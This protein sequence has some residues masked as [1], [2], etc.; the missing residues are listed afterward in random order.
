MNEYRFTFNGMEKDDEVKGNGNSYDF[1]AR[2]H[3]SRIGRFLSLDPRKFDFPF[4][5][6]YCFAAN[7]PIA[8]IDEYG[9]GPQKPKRPKT[10]AV[11]TP[12]S[13]SLVAQQATSKLRGQMRYPSSQGIEM[14]I[15]FEDLSLS[16][17]DVDGSRKGNATIGF[18]HKVHDGAI[19][20]GASEKGLKKPITMNDAVELLAADI[21]SINGTLS[22]RVNNRKLSNKMT[23]NEYDLAFDLEFN[24]GN[25][26]RYLDKLGK[27]KDLEANG[28]TTKAD[29]KMSKLT[30]WVS[31]QY[32]GRDKKRGI[33]RAYLNEGTYGTKETTFEEVE[34]IGK[35]SKKK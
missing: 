25:S 1:G 29:K 9:E 6:P 5:S 21:E 35:K 14:T 20:G 11:L 10:R 15:S 32:P 19:N 7:N 34:I 28:K 17:Y 31:R 16:L 12:F 13:A 2:I 24:T 18:G 27:I 22:N 8:F 23:Q 30:N 26:G 3:D 33:A 4:M